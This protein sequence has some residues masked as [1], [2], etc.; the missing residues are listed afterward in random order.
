M[1]LC[2][3]LAL[4]SC[5]SLASYLKMLVLSLKHRREFPFPSKNLLYNL[6]G[7][8]GHVLSVRVCL[9]A[10][11]T[12]PDNGWRSPQAIGHNTCI[13]DALPIGTYRLPALTVATRLR[14]FRWA[15]DKEGV[16]LTQSAQDRLPSLA[17]SATWSGGSLHRSVARMVRQRLDKSHRIA[18]TFHDLETVFGT[19]GRSTSGFSTFSIEETDDEAGPESSSG[20]EE[21]PF[22]FIGGSSAAKASL[23]DALTLDSCKRGML[24]SMGIDPPIGVLFYGPPGCGTCLLLPAILLA[25]RFVSH[26]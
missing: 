10:I 15:F 5:F 11:V 3:R 21:D 7:N 8:G 17:V 19:V 16:V 1:C 13:F 2:A 6:G 24:Q 4:T 9:V 25:I 23:R 20:N 12:C 14:S 26:I 22:G 18:A